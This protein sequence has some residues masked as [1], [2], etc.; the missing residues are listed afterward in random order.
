MKKDYSSVPKKFKQR[1]QKS[2][3]DEDQFPSKKQWKDDYQRKLKH[4]PPKNWNDQ[5]DYDE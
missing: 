1:N 5:K 2:W 3:V 4:R